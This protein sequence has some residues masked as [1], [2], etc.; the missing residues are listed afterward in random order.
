M[1]LSLPGLVSGAKFIHCQSGKTAGNKHAT[2]LANVCMQC[3]KAGCNRPSTTHDAG[4]FM[5]AG[6]GVAYKLV[7]AGGPTLLVQPTS[8][9]AQRGGF[10]LNNLW[11]TPHSDTGAEAEVLPRFLQPPFT[12][13]MRVALYYFAALHYL[14]CRDCYV[15]DQTVWLYTL[16]HPR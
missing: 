16:L 11:V 12:N 1:G 14:V 9:V 15:H 4:R 10:A 6:K 2:R 5:G 7:P 13:I 8:S 3:D